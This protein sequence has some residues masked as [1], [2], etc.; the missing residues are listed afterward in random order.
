MLPSQILTTGQLLE[1]LTLNQQAQS[2]NDLNFMWAALM[3]QNSLVTQFLNSASLSALP[4]LNLSKSNQL[5]ETDNSQ[6][7]IQT[8]GKDSNS[9]KITAKSNKLHANSP[10]SV[11][12]PPN[13]YIIW[14]REQRKKI[15]KYSFNQPNGISMELGTRWRAMSAS[16]KHPYFEEQKR[17]TELFEQNVGFKYENRGRRTFLVDGEFVSR[18]EY[19]AAKKRQNHV[20]E[21]RPPTSK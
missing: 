10:N 14:S 21:I 7:K 20:L 19:M 6:M 12:K 1:Q 13:A 9:A 5:Q 15:G 16:E 11:K 17:L 8:P 2:V 18:R 4:N 3:I